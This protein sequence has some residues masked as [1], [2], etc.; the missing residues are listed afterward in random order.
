MNK[1]GNTYHVKTFLGNNINRT[2]HAQM[3]REFIVWPF[4]DGGPLI[5]LFGGFHTNTGRMHD[6]GGANVSVFLVP[7]SGV[8]NHTSE[9][10]CSRGLG[11]SVLQLNLATHN[12]CYMY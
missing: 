6:G 11:S 7:V 9:T 1:D 5:P 8:R 2:F 12:T 3:K 4:A 10:N